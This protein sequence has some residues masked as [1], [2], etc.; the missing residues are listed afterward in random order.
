M[1]VSL[2]FDLVRCEEPGVP[3]YGYKIQDDG[4]YANTFVLYSCN[5]GYSLHG[6]STLTCLSGDRRVW[7]KPLPSCIAEC[8]GHITGAVSGRI[9]SPGYPAPYDNNLHC[10]WTIEADTGKT[11]SLHFIVFDTEIGHDI[12]R[13]WDGPSG[14]SDGGILLKE[15][16][17]PALPEDI[18]STFN[19]LTL[20][21][22]SD[23]F[24]S[25]QGF[26]IQFSTTTATTCN[27]PGIPV[28]GSRYGDSKEPG[29]SMTFQC[30]PGYQL[31]GQDT[32]TCV[33]MD[34]RFYWQPDPPT[35]IATCGGNISGPSGVILSP[36]YPQPYPPGKECDWRIRVNPDF[37]IA[38]IFKS[39]NM[40]PSYDFLHI[41]EGE[42]SNGPLL[43]SLQGNQA[44]ERI[45][46]SGNSLFLAFRSDASLGMSGFAIEYREKPREACFDPGN[47]MN[48]SRTGYDYKLGSQ[49]SYNCHHGYTTVGGDTITCVMGHDGKPVWDRA[50]PSCK[51]TET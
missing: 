39:F 43:S 14:P 44:P 4:H 3:S 8:G 16:S 2:G 19:I 34:N 45:E 17:G 21:F 49:V 13:V 33:R 35:C 11:I 40:E 7:D 22:D 23:Y 12:L 20:Q 15:W 50:L 25:K 6:S 18:H 37:V 42:D 28:N 5:P 36:N 47:I 9:L 29:D 24:I 38:L 30:D 46:S 1:C 26:S 27:D 31:E 10:T 51:V 32:I 41:Y 48:A